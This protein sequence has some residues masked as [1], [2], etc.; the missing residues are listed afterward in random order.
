[1]EGEAEEASRRIEVAAIK[2]LERN[3]YKRVVLL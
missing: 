1:V 3:S 2:V